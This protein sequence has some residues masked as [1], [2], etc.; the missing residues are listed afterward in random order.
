MTIVTNN[1]R[2]MYLYKGK[3]YNVKPL[4]KAIGKLKYK[5]FKSILD[6]KYIIYIFYK[7]IYYMDIKRR[8]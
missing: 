2:I 8:L 5:T 1:G 4:S 6:K 3:K 7:N